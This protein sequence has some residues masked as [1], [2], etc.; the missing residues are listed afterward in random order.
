MRLLALDT[1]TTIVQLRFPKCRDVFPVPELVCVQLWDGTDGGVHM[2]DEPDLDVLLMEAIDDSDTLIVGQNIPFDI[3]VL[4][5]AFP[6]LTGPWRRAAFE[7]RVLDTMVLATLREPCLKNK[8]LRALAAFHLGVTLE[9]KGDVQV[10]F[11]RDTPLSKEQQDYALKD[12]IVTHALAAHLRTV[13]LGAIYRG[14][15]MRRHEMECQVNHK[16]PAGRGGFHAL[17]HVYSTCFINTRVLLEPRGWDIDHVLFE[18]HRAVGVAKIEAAAH[19]LLPSGFI[20]RARDTDAPQTPGGLADISRRKFQYD[21]EADRWETVRK[22]RWVYQPARWKLSQTAIRTAFEETAVKLGLEDVPVSVKTQK[23][24]LTY[25]YWREHRDAFPPALQDFM[26]YARA[27]KYESIYFNIWGASKTGRVY[28]TYFVPGTETLRH[29]ASK[30]NFHQIAKKLR[31][32]FYVKDHVIVGADYSALECYT[33]CHVLVNLGLRG[34]LYETLAADGD[35][36]SITAARM[37]GGTPDDYPKGS[38]ERQA[39]KALNFGIPGGL[40][41][42]KMY[43][44]GR[45]GYGLAW[46]P[47]E[48]AKMYWAYREA[49]TDIDQYLKWFGSMKPWHLKP[50]HMDRDEWL[51]SLGFEDWP[52]TWELGKALDKGRHYNVQLPSG[53]R[54]PAR[55]FSQGTNCAFQHIGAVAISHALNLCCAEGL[56]VIGAVHDAAYLAVPKSEDPSL[57]SRKLETIMEQALYEVCPEAPRQTVEAEIKETFF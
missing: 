1:E 18:K 22:G 24:S 30:P 15:A 38:Q 56:P 34:P 53:A 41:A 31:E 8:S 27:Q 11:Q 19:A 29:A 33:L 2:H 21:P 23:L 44:Y 40:G 32:I 12:A 17:D 47:D 25:D 13:P 9:G 55:N 5:K 20:S 3:N 52:G 49:F 4:I 50:K 54:I 39:A 26:A 6:D 7:N 37:L 35:M 48:A 14:R 28:P 36:H 10:S 45:Q 43:T 16:L 51:R 57:T 42:K 46:T